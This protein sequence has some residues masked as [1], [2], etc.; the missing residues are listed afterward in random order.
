[1]NP[2]RTNAIFVSASYRAS[3][4]GMKIKLSH[5][6]GNKLMEDTIRLM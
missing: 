3:Q 2:K 1:M 5:T 6:N 4:M